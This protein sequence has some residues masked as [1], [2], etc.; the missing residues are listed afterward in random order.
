MKLIYPYFTSFALLLLAA[1]GKV[2]PN[3]QIDEGSVSED[4]YT[5]EEIGWTIPIPKGWE[6]VTLNQTKEYLEKGIDAVEE[7]VD[8]DVDYSNLKNLIS[9]K[10][11]RSNLFSSTS[12]PFTIEYEGEWEENNELLKELILET[13]DK[14]G[15]KAEASPTEIELI[16][17]L[18]F[19]TYEFTMKLPNGDVFLRQ[20]IYS[21]HINGFDF[22]ANISYDN[23]TFGSE[24][25]S[26][27]K[28]SKFKR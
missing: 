10:K 18:E 22:G 28:Q 11:N 15:I 14:Q 26:A 25:L 23:E 13:F 27:W 24:M 2:D 12:E 1:C 9:F 16:D 19:Q 5:S 3:Q 17:E 7:V 20:K 8:A 21:R 6:I 4:I